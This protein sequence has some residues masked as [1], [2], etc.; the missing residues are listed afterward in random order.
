MED[1]AND[2]L[3]SFEDLREIS[4]A[5]GLFAGWALSSTCFG[6]LWWVH[7]SWKNRRLRIAGILGTLT[8]IAVLNLLVIKFA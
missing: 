2:Y 5:L 7:N 8:L 3:A 4:I 6:L 1:A